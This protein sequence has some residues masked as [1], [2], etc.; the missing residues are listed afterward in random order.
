M[1]SGLGQEFAAMAQRAQAKPGSVS[2][3]EVRTALARGGQK[4]GEWA[5]LPMPIEGLRMV[6][7]PSYPFAENLGH[8][9]MP[10]PSVHVCR[11]SDV[12]E[13]VA[14]RNHWRSYKDGWGIEIWQ[15]GDKFF[16]T[17]SPRVNTAPM[18]IETINAARAWDY[19]AELRAMETL[20]RHV[21]DWAFRCYSL[22]GMFLET[23]KRSGVIYAFRRL[24]P[25]VAMTGHPDANGRDRGVR[26][27]CTL[28]AHPIGYYD[29]SWA[30][31][32]VPTDDVLS[33]LLLMRADE[34]FLWRNCNQH[35]AWAPESGL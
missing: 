4:M 31:A 18:L 29:G 33:H 19:E 20:Q 1:G 7:H 2:W 8:T 27:L 14:M 13:D 21:T 23:S 32:L 28:C 16:F 6:I 25:T 3:E 9:F 26:I 12:R 24:R 5:G 30:G 22:T 11:N 15:E 10:Q 34:H 17:R 35:P